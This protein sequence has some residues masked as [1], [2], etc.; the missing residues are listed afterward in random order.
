MYSYTC[1]YIKQNGILYIWIP[2]A[3]HSLSPYGYIRMPMY[4][5]NGSLYIYID[6][7]HLLSPYSMYTYTC[8]CIHTMVVGVDTVTP[9]CLP[10]DPSP[11]ETTKL[12]PCARG[13]SLALCARVGGIGIYI[14][15]YR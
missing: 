1:L 7:L 8:V 14:Y 12:A 2:A 6:T 13:I 4:E 3:L 5:H 11:S 9:T 10:Y 15:I